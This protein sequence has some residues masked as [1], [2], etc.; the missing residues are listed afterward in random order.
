MPAT[1][2]AS[3]EIAIYNRKALSARAL[4]T[5]IDRA[6]SEYRRGD[7]E[8]RGAV[9]KAGLASTKV[10]ALI[11]KKALR[12]QQ[13]GGGIGL[14]ILIAIMAS[15]ATEKVARDLWNKVL[16]PYIERHVAGD[17]VGAKK[18]VQTTSKTKAKPVKRA[19]ALPPAR[20]R[21]R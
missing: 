16:L 5:A 8:I 9:E 19:R 1:D 21:V 12:V 13:R 15:K 18:K 20:R 10:D 3:V 11:A 17:A 14:E 7:P 6:L 2:S 4:Q